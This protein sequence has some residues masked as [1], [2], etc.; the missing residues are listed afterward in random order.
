MNLVFWSV[1]ERLQSVNLVL[2]KAAATVRSLKHPLGSIW[3]VVRSENQSLD[4]MSKTYWSLTESLWTLKP[5]LRPRTEKK[6]WKRGLRPI[7]SACGL[8]ME[9]SRWKSGLRPSRKRKVGRRIR[10]TPNKQINLTYLGVTV[11]AC[12]TT[13]PPKT[14]VIC[15]VR[16]TLRAEEK[17]HFKRT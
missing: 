9:E 12:A 3:L 1:P 6:N 2:L 8:G 17:I 5:G 16:L 11:L 15:G 7:E 14:Q 4:R 10:R 13:A